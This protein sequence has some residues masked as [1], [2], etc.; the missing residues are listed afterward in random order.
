MKQWQTL[1]QKRLWV[2]GAIA[3]VALILLAMV[4]PS[5]GD[6]RLSGSS[7]GR[8]P[9]GYGAWYRYMGDRGTPLERWQQPF[10][11]L[12]EAQGVTLV[13]VEGMAYQNALFLEEEEWVARGNRLVQ[14]GVPGRVTEADFSSQIPSD[15]G[16][17]RIQTRRR[18]IGQNVSTQGTST[19]LLQDQHGVLIWS[20]RLGEG[21]VISVVP[22]DFAA[23][24]YQDVPGN[25]E[26]LAEAVVREGDRLLID[27]YIHGFKDTETITEE[28][29]TNWADYLA[30]TPLMMLFIQG[31]VMIIVLVWAMNQRSRPPRPLDSP[32]TNNSKAYIEALAGVLQKAG[33]SDF[34]V[35]MI[36]RE[37]QLQIQR[38]M[39]LGSEPVEA[40]QLLQSW[41]R[42][43]GRPASELNRVLR[44]YWTQQSLS[45]PAL[46]EWI[47]AIES[48]HRTLDMGEAP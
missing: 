36:G 24:A 14:I 22:P 5:G 45:A 27:E 30:Q 4:M 9:D 25:Y 21:D 44:P 33:N 2:I 20:T 41:Q 39:G 47:K 23:N 28:V 12:A 43:T 29:A 17:I 13:Q 26:F 15:A 6:A 48:V 31:T 35:S 40:D 18:S 10:E 1:G 16:L 7:Y 3:F 34:V 8:A 19:P 42:Q 32:E 11:N 46:M 37:E 38:R